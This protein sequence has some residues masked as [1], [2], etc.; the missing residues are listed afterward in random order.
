MAAK[1]EDKSVKL[2]G[3]LDFLRFVWAIEH[4][5]Q[6]ASK[7][8][9][10]RTGVTERQRLVLKIL[11]K[12]A[13]AS[14]SDIAGILHLHPSTMT[15]IV[16]RLTARGYI[17]RSKH[18]EDARKGK[19][20]LT[21]KGKA[22]NDQKGSQAYE[23]AVKKALGKFD[24]AKLDVAR[25]VLSAIAD[26]LGAKPAP[27]GKPAAKKAAAKPAAKKAAAKPAAKKAPAKAAA[28]PAAKKAPAKAAAKPAAKAAAKPAA[29]AAAKP[30]AKAAAKP[31]AKAA[32]KG[33]GKK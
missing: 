6:S 18:A 2:G 24:D 13:S 26:E 33:K 12:N 20:E 29:K 28:K 15:G 3:P 1:K 31:A 8:M 21:A 10:R 9:A 30:A 16:Q 27:E 23:T 25:D 11:G 7:T 14:A 19:L 32:A 17:A 5:L 4:E 22:V